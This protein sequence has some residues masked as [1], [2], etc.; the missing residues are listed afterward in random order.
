MEKYKVLDKMGL[1]IMIQ[2]LIPGDDTQGVN[3]NSY[4][5]DGK[6]QVEFTAQKVR[7][8]PPFFGSPRV[9]ESRHIPEIIEPGRA[10]L[11]GINY[12]GF[13]CM[14]FKKDSR[15][16]VYKLME[17]NPRHNLSGSLAVKCGINFPYIAYKH[18]MYGEILK[19]PMFTEGM[20]W[21]D[22][23]KD[24]MHFLVSRR[25]EGYTIKQYAKPYFSKKVFAILSLNDPLPFLKRNVY[26]AGQGLKK[27]KALFKSQ[28]KSNNG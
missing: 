21:I 8:D 6:P 4:F 26:V 19:A 9:L 5:I 13:S 22:I 28:R 24:L 1:K 7:I 16:G 15:D 18:L 2:E 3:Y 27:I 20:Y 10:L 23:T 17:I 25:L 14:E 12:N 11:K